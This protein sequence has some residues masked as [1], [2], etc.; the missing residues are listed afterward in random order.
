MRKTP[1]S[2]LRRGGVSKVGSNKENAQHIDVG[3]ADGQ[4]VT[5]LEEHYESDDSDCFIINPSPDSTPLLPPPRVDYCKIERPQSPPST[6]SAE[7][8]VSPPVGIVPFTPL[9]MD[10]S[11]PSKESFRP[12]NVIPT[13]PLVQSETTVDTAGT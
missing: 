4:K 13:A 9:V 2:V 1:V 12:D 3:S 11:A 10:T 5:V 7:S 6:P 8:V